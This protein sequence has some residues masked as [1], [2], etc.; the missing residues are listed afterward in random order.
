MIAT[1]DGLRDEVTSEELPRLG[2]WL[3]RQRN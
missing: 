1:E 2:Q 3:S